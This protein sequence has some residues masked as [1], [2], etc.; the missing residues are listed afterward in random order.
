MLCSG[1]SSE[2][3]F[4]QESGIK[5]SFTPF[6]IK[7][8]AIALHEFPIVNSSLV[9]DKIVL[10]RNSN[11]GLAVARENK[12]LIVPVIHNVENMDLVE[13]SRKAEELSEKARTDSLSLEDLRD[14][15]FTITNVG[16]FGAILNTPIINVPQSAILGVGAIK[17]KPAVI[18]D[19]IK[20][21]IVDVSLTLR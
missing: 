11:I 2:P 12:G 3:K 10:K 15:T 13:I 17:K 20:D 21:Q 7:A 9:D 6:I 19:Q 16:M 1:K 8:V 14:G 18:D 4:Q 5:I